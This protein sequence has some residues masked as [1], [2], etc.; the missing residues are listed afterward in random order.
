MLR[1]LLTGLTVSG[2]IVDKQSRVGQGS[3]WQSLRSYR[4]TER[5]GACGAAVRRRHQGHDCSYG[6]FVEV[7]NIRNTLVRM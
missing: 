3:A 6:S 4:A 2:D 5:L 1:K 7:C